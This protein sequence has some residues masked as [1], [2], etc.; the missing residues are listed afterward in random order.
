MSV[1]PHDRRDA[2]C[3]ESDAADDRAGDDEGRRQADMLGEEARAEQ[4]DRRGEQSETV[5]QRHDAPQHSRVDAALDDGDERRVEDAA[6][7]AFDQ[8]KG[9]EERECR[10]RQHAR[11]GEQQSDGQVHQVYQHDA[12]D[13]VGSGAHDGAADQRA[14]APHDLDQAHFVGPSAEV[15]QRHQRK[16]HADGHD[17]EPH[18]DGQREKPAHA[19]N[20]V[21]GAEPFAELAPETGLLRRA[22]FGIGNADQQQGGAGDKGPRDVQQQDVADARQVDQQ[23][24]ERGPDDVRQRTDDL[25]D[26]GDA[27]QLLLGREQ[28][29]RSLHGGGVESR[30]DGAA[31]QQHV[32]MPHAGDVEPEKYGEEQGAQR[33]EAVRQNHRPFT[34]P[35]V[36]IDADQR[37]QQRLGKH[38]GNGGQR[39]HLRRACFEAHPEDDGEG[40]DRT[41]QD[42][43][44]LSAPNDG[45]CL[46]P[47]FHAAFLRLHADPRE[48]EAYT[49]LIGPEPIVLFVRFEQHEIFDAADVESR[50]VGEGAADLLSV[51]GHRLQ[52]ETDKFQARVVLNAER[53]RRRI[54]EQLLLRLVEEPQRF[55]AAVDSYGLG[56]LQRRALGLERRVFG[57]VFRAG[58]CGRET[59]Q[60]KIFEVFHGGCYL[61]VMYLTIYCCDSSSASVTTAMMVCSPAAR[62]V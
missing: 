49:R 25:V 61:T 36:H 26:A 51:G 4:S 48:D 3:D 47:V 37:T 10:G 13:A 58:G 16:H 1:E 20:G 9:G 43:G 14:A 8:G 11:S 38:A 40:D 55:S 6:R 56:L 52:L 57:F 21:H 31:C 46:F 5:V 12:V 22:A 62:V 41:A 2:E 44:Q 30:P 27:R 17:E 59:D 53:K 32:D 50:V 42:R 24:A 54:D 29:H 60:Q 18:E 34:V 15:L 23:G 19:R 28:R 39:Q 7:D 35:A 45:E 33:D